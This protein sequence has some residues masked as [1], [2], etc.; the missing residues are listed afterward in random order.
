MRTLLAAVCTLA[1]GACFEEPVRERM[2]VT[3][4]SDA[5][6]GVAVETVIADPGSRDNPALARRLTELRRSLEQESDSWSRRFDLLAPGFDRLVRERADGALVRVER[7]A[8]AEDLDALRSFLA[9][10][11]LAAAIEV[12]AGELRVEI[13]PAGV[14]RASR[15]QRDRVHAAVRGWSEAVAATYGATATLYA[16]LATRPERTAACLSALFAEALSEED[17]RP[18][19]ELT[20]AEREAVDA[21]RDARREVVAVFEVPADEAYSLNELSHLVYDPFPAQLTITVPGAPLEAVG[22]EPGPDGSF[23][24]A[25][26]GLF[27]ALETLGDL[28]ASPD[29]LVS[30]V[31]AARAGRSSTLALAELEAQPLRAA[32]PRPDEVRTALEARLLP[33]PVYRLLVPLGAPTH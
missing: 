21:V 19:L 4:H 14:A 33:A 30:Y 32:T 25:G 10:A 9:D 17:R 15:V 8:E 24:V 6:Y 20:D 28:W 31:R 26:L 12:Q 22:F 16:M 29:P 2:T 27:E 7:S 18:G 3:F 5:T 1:L 23:I 13:V 11:G